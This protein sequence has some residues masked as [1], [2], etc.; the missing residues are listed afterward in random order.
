MDESGNLGSSSGEFTTMGFL[1]LEKRLNNE[2][3]FREFLW[4]F[5]LS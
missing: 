3:T 4:I 1:Y 5:E 2:T